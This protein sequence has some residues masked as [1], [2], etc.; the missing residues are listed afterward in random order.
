M[1]LSPLNPTRF[2]GTLLLPKKDAQRLKLEKY[3]DPTD[4]CSDHTFDPQEMRF[5]DQSRASRRVLTQI[6]MGDP[7]QEKIAVALCKEQGVPHAYLPDG[8][9]T[10][11]LLKLATEA[12]WSK[13]SWLF[14]AFRVPLAQMDRN[15]QM[16]LMLHPPPFGSM[17]SS[18]DFLTLGADPAR[19][20][21]LAGIAQYI[22]GK[23]Y[24]YAFIPS[25]PEDTPP[26]APVKADEPST[27]ILPP[28]PKKA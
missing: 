7:A 27:V 28:K 10:P 8:K 1:T 22:D 21:M 17:S 11:A 2:S 25:E 23:G 16:D 6:P 14:S 26:P 4:F 20:D 3:S 13:A 12:L 9:D 5:V 19:K 15:A 24:G 18:Q